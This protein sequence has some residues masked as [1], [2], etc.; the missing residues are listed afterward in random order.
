MRTESQNQASCEN[1]A[2]SHG[3]TTPEGKLASARNAL[4]HGMLSDTIVLECESQDRFLELVVSLHEEFQPQ[5]PFE[6][7][8][9]EN[10]AVARWRL[11]RVRGMETAGIDHEMR[12][13]AEMRDLD[14]DSAT[15]ASLAFR[16]LSD[17]S[18]SLELI[19][20]YEARYDR[21]Y[22]RAHRCFIETRDRRTPPSAPAVPIPPAPPQ[23]DPQ[24]QAEPE[25]VLLPFEPKPPVLEKE[26]I[27]NKRPHSRE[28]HAHRSFQSSRRNAFIRFHPHSS[29]AGVLSS[30]VHQ[31]IIR[32]K[33]KT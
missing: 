20:R 15:R 18:R 28:S 12:R 16:T 4:K 14:E 32:I 6:E 17:D 26:V 30:N 29:V 27:A 7:T 5:T 13:Q 2:K 8:L 1:G 23:I 19:N 3:A 22:Y 9:I 33:G 24:P 25:K 31:E 21:Q 11:M 10:M